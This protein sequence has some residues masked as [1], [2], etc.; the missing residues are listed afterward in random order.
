MRR[1]ALSLHGATRFTSRPRSAGRRRSAVTRCAALLTA[2]TALLSCGDTGDSGP[3]IIAAT[4]TIAEESVTDLRALAVTPEEL[5]EIREA[6]EAGAGVPGT[7]D[8]C[9]TALEQV[10]RVGPEQCAHRLC[11]YV[12]RLQEQPQEALLEA[13]DRRDNSDLC[14]DRPEL[15]AVLRITADDLASPSGTT[16]PTPSPSGT[17]TPSTSPSATG[18]PS[19]AGASES[20]GTGNGGEEESPAGVPGTP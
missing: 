18:S 12:G 4:G 14:T 17:A 7:N 16:S 9:E 15:C 1:Q 2:A 6:C 10:P 19:S 8:D 11:V 3:G 13:K 5:E 20:P